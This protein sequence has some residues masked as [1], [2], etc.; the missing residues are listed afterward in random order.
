MG[1][2]VLLAAAVY[3]AD[4]FLKRKVE[5][6]MPENAPPREILGGRILVRRITNHG[7]AGGLFEDRPELV[8]GLTAAGL[9]LVLL[10]MLKA[11]A[12]DENAASRVSCALMAGGSLSNVRDRF[13]NGGVTDYLSIRSE[14]FPKAGDIVFNL[15]DAAIF[16]GALI[17]IFG[18]KK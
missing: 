13:E 8:K 2:S 17:G 11:V 14:R 16:A 9:A 12:A 15:G 18:G 7:L 1:G 5:K 3:R 6:N 4:C 10:R